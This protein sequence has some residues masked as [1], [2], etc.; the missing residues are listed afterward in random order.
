MEITDAAL[1]EQCLAGKLDAYGEL[2]QRHQDAVFNFIM[3]MIHNWHETADLTQ[4]TFIRAQRKLGYYDARFSFRNWLFSIAANQT[5][6][7]FRP[8]F[9]HR[10]TEEQSAD[11]V[12]ASDPTPREDPR[13]E[14]AKKLSRGYRK[15]SV[16]RSSSNT[17]KAAPTTRSPARWASALARPKCESCAPAMNSWNNS[18]PFLQKGHYEIQSPCRTRRH[19]PGAGRPR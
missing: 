7:R 4:E 1:V 2:I 16:P 11:P 18:A 14:A 9:R 17:W 10:R 19:R 12:F 6:N 5:K 15:R 13:Q 3:K 8:L